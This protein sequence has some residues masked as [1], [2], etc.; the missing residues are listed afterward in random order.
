MTVNID[1]ESQTLIEDQQAN[2]KTLSELNINQGRTI[3]EQ[4]KRIDEYRLEHNRNIKENIALESKVDELQAQV[5]AL[6]A[7]IKWLTS[8]RMKLE[9]EITRLAALNKGGTDQ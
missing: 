2:L 4:Q 6:E 3:A 5:K 1:G 8:N 9:G 7:D